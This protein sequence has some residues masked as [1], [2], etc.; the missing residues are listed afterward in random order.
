[1]LPDKKVISARDLAPPPLTPQQ[2]YLMTETWRR[3]Q[4]AAVTFA[5]EVREVPLMLERDWDR[6]AQRIQTRLGTCDP[7]IDEFWCTKFSPMTTAWIH[8]HPR[9]DEVATAYDH[10]RLIM[11]GQFDFTSP[12]YAHLVKR[13]S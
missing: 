6:I 1:M 12:K 11:G 4:L 3:R 10:Y 8:H 9:L 5:I 13:K 2:T 7:E